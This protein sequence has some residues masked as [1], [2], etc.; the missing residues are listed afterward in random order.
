M[1]RQGQP[2]KKGHFKIRADKQQLLF[3]EIYLSQATSSSER[4][5]IS[6]YA[7]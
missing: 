2:I 1:E 7:G 5:E 6:E 4:V 3:V